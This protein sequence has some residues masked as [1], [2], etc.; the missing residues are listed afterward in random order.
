MPSLSS[1]VLTTVVEEP[2]GA[3]AI[4]ESANTNQPLEDEPATHDD[5]WLFAFS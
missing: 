3:P 2:S 5:F 4:V 1:Q